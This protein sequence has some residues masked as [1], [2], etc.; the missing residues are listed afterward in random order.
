MARL[1]S[2]DLQIRINSA[3]TVQSDKNG[4]FRDFCEQVFLTARAHNN[5]LERV[6]AEC[7]SN[8][9]R[10]NSLLSDSSPVSLIILSTLV[11]VKS[12]YRQKNAFVSMRRRLNAEKLQLQY[13]NENDPRL[14]KGA[15]CESNVAVIQA[16]AKGD[17]EYT[18]PTL[19]HDYSC[20]YL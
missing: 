4:F 10:I 5:W 3:L 15:L 20:C 17:N 13:F 19:H 11:H 12:V 7:G 18:P 1:E 6:F 2:I 8:Q 16:P 14:L 9:E